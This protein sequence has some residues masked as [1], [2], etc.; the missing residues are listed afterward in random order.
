MNELRNG[1]YEF[2]IDIYQE[3]K[4]T[5]YHYVAII[6]INADMYEYLDESA[7][8]IIPHANRPEMVEQVYAMDSEYL[9]SCANQKLLAT[10]F[11]VHKRYL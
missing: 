5:G 3:W 11:I 10:T 9:L 2:D 1:Y 7:F 4:R 6:T 8:E